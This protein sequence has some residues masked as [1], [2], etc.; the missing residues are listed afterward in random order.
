MGVGQLF[1][2]EE[3]LRNLHDVKTHGQAAKHPNMKLP[4]TLHS[5][6]YRGEY[7]TVDLQTMRLM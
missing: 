7:Q 5:M 6:Y 3:T 2:G 4:A 1:K